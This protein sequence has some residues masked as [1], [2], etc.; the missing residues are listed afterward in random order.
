MKS[1]SLR[2]QRSSTQFF[3]ALSAKIAQLQAAGKDVL[4]LDI[5]SPDMPPAPHIVEA[6]QRAVADPRMHGYGSHKGPLALRKAWGNLYL[7]LH[8]GRIGY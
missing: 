8:G 4:R 6:M 5:G 3:A 7:R 2:M 1:L